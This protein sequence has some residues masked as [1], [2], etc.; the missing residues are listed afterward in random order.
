MMMQE[1][2]KKIDKL[3]DKLDDRIDKLDDKIDKLGSKIDKLGNK[4]DNIN[5]TIISVL[6]ARRWVVVLWNMRLCMLTCPH[7]SIL[8]CDA[9]CG[10]A[11][12][13]E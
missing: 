12:L 11:F 6:A 2:G 10:C 9:S 3:D 1:L 13:Q 7:R 8:K 4:L 5:S